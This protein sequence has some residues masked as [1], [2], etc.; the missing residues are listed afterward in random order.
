MQTV[1]TLI[2]RRVLSSVS[3]MF[4][5]HPLSVSR[6]KWVNTNSCP[7]DNERAINSDGTLN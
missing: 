5:N 6:L 7:Y 2:R 1:L 3:A 4:V